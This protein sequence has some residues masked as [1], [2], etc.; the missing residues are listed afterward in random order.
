MKCTE[1][2]QEKS[3]RPYGK[4]GAWI[5][6]PCAMK[7]EEETDRNFQAQ[8]DAAAKVSDVILIG[9]PTGPRPLEN[10]NDTR[11]QH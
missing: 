3:L 10:K 1:C 11:K 8:L 6:F 9:E 4:N 2:N 5:C 7:D